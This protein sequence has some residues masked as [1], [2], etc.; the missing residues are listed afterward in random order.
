M[1][2]GLRYRPAP[3]QPTSRW[4]RLL[5]LVRLEFGA[6]FRTKWGVAI[7]LATLLPSIVRLVILLIWTGALALGGGGPAGAGMRKMGERPPEQVQELLPDHVGFYTEGVV[8]PGWGLVMLLVLTSLVTARAIAKDRATNALELYW[9][10]GISPLGYFLGKGFGCFLVTGAMTIAAP[11]VLWVT[12]V[13]LAEDWSFLSKT[14]GFMP[15]VVLGLTVFTAALTTICILLSAI[16]GSPNLAAILW[17]LLIAGSEAFG[18]IIGNVLKFPAL[19]ASVS[20][21]DAA[22]TLA[23][24]CAGN[25]ERDANPMGAAISLL[26]IIAV[27]SLLLRRRLRLSEAVA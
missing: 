12:G 23:R 11:F 2:D 16:A 21:F 4:S 26:T 9:T 27:L 10:R 3:Y 1:I 19:G 8:A 7:F 20:V 24:A 15:G 5:P 18:Q 6:I 25:A 17:C 13:F 14:W 22:G